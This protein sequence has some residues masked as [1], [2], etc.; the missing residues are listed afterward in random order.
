[1]YIIINIYF[2]IWKIK[3][4]MV[5]LHR[6]FLMWHQLLKLELALVLQLLLRCQHLLVRRQTLPPPHLIGKI[7]LSVSIIQIV[8]IIIF[9]LWYFIAQFDHNVLEKREKFAVNLRK[10]KTQDILKA[11]RRKI[12]EAIN[13]QKAGGSQ[14]S[15]NIG[16]NPSENEVISDD[17]LSIEDMKNQYY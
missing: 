8:F 17:Q 11:K 16:S 12:I 4:H 14:N 7:F 13:T 1:M 3:T 2:E 6:L 15:K 9:W 10:K 5:L